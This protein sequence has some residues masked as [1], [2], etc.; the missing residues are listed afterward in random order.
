MREA[1]KDLRKDR[2][3]PGSPALGCGKTVASEPEKIPD[4]GKMD[5]SKIRNNEGQRLGSNVD[6]AIVGQQS[7]AGAIAIS[8]LEQICKR[9]A[10]GRAIRIG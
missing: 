9:V 6:A 2:P 5:I 1:A 8:A 10:G 3:A 4:F 7:I